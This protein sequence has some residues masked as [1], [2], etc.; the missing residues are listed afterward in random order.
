MNIVAFI[1]IFCKENNKQ[2]NVLEYCVFTI[3]TIV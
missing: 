3:A 1:V 2:E